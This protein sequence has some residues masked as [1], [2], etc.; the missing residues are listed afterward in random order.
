MKLENRWI[1]IL[2]IVLLAI[3][4]TSTIG[5][6]KNQELMFFTY[7]GYYK[8]SPNPILHSGL[9][10]IKV[11][12]IEKFKDLQGTIYSK[13]TYSPWYGKI[14]SASLDFLKE[15]ETQK[16][17]IMYYGDCTPKVKKGDIL[18]LCFFPN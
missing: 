4:G 3:F 5:K 10:R 18:R 11:E 2:N 13:I 1:L 9:A 8:I 15:I 6:A 7:G 17:T 16:V 12:S 14:D